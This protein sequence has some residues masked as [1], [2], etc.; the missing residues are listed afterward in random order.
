[1]VFWCLFTDM[2]GLEG[3]IE[4]HGIWGWTFSLSLC[5]HKK[6]YSEPNLDN[7]CQIRYI[8]SLFYTRHCIRQLTCVI[9]LRPYS[10][11]KSWP[12]FYLYFTDED[13]QSQSQLQ[14]DKA[15]TQSAL[16]ASR[17]TIEKL[18][19]YSLHAW[20]LHSGTKSLR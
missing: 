10:K 5:F 15:W 12:M 9:S 4:L 11:P 13:I 6:A 7:N 20:R 18:S 3:E 8:E 19:R 1:M 16:S 14:N 17:C 2:E